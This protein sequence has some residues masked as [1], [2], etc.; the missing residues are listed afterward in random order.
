MPELLCGCR[1][2][3][4]RDPHNRRTRCSAH[5]EIEK[6]EVSTHLQIDTGPDFREQVLRNGIGR[7]DAILY[8]HA[9]FDHTVGLDD[10]RR[11]NMTQKGA[12]PVYGRDSVISEL[13]QKFSHC[14]NPVQLGGG[15]PRITPVPVKAPFQV[16]NVTVEPIDVVHGKI[17]IF[18]YRIGNFAYVTD[19]SE[20]STESL[21]KMKGLDLLV[22]NALRFRKHPTHFN[23]EQALEVVERVNPRR[24]L[25]VHIT[26]DLE[27]KTVNQLLPEHVR[28]GY[29]G[30]VVELDHAG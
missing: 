5:L 9:H 2:C 8:S 25:L 30:Q 23:L 6:D 4:S 17:P 1:V 22:L 27:H 14:F 28:L 19:A 24:A 12:I 26:H 7:I 18:G 29:D 3:T 10:I 11:F 16:G 13:V 21:E 15:V 20:I